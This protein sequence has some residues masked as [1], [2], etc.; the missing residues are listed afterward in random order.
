MPL[1]VVLAPLVVL[2]LP[3]GGVLDVEPLPWCRA[4]DPVVTTCVETP[5]H[6]VD[7]STTRREGK[8]MLGPP[9]ALPA[10]TDTANPAEIALDA[11]DKLR[12][13]TLWPASRSC[14]QTL[15][16]S[17]TA[18]WGAPARVVDDPPS[19]SALRLWRK[20]GHEAELFV[21]P[22]SCRVEFRSAEEAKERAAELDKRAAAKRARP[23]AP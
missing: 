10:W 21:Y 9:G 2:G 17:I 20:Q 22:G 1:L 16:R 3:L 14:L 6:L 4:D 8:L 23:V 7:G 12:R 19:G 11:E 5:L 18:G 15:S 13:I